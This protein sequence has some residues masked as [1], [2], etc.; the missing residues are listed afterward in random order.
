MMIAAPTYSHRALVTRLPPLR[1]GRS[2]SSNSRCHATAILMEAST[3]TALPMLSSTV[4]STGCVR[5]GRP[6]GFASMWAIHEACIQPIAA[7]SIAVVAS[8]KTDIRSTSPKC[9]K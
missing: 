2:S 9:Q 8:Q 7:S 1:P 6:C 5:S 3:T 4:I